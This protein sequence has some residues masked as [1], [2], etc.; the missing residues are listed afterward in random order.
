[1][2][3][4]DVRRPS[5]APN[6]ASV[7]ASCWSENRRES[8]FAVGQRVVVLASPFYGMTG[9]VLRPATLLWKRAW[10][11]ELDTPE[12][13]FA[14]RRTRVAQSA[15]APIEHADA[16]RADSGAARASTAR[17]LFSALVPLLS[18]AWLLLHPLLAGL[19]T[20]F[21]MGLLVVAYVRRR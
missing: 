11:V 21:I 14:V 4:L 13:R 19:C 1:M 15:L 6:R 9:T 20:A 3:V 10:L 12:K 2:K 16:V 18:A 7:A 8:A 17:F 5:G